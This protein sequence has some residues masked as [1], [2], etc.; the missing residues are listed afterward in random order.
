MDALASAACC[1]TVRRVILDLAIVFLP[2]TCLNGDA[3]IYTIMGTPHSGAPLR[4][5]DCVR[6]LPEGAERQVVASVLSPR[7]QQAGAPI[8]RCRQKLGP[9]AGIGVA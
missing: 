4:F 8:R 5:L 6:H 2:V 1:N 7:S 3:T 9:R